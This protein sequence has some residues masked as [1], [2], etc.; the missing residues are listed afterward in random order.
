MQGTPS[1]LGRAIVTRNA[2][3]SGRPRGA[4]SERRLV[5]HVG[6]PKTGTTTIQRALTALEPQLRQRGV[7][8]PAAGRGGRRLAVHA[9]LRQALKTRAPDP[10]RGVL[11]ELL[12]ELRAS[13]AQQFV[14]S[15]EGLSRNFAPQAPKAIAK[16][17]ESAGLDVAIVGYVRPQC[18]YIESL[19]AQMVK[20]G[21]GWLPF[22]VF[23]G[24]SLLRRFRPRQCWLDY[25]RLFAPWR[26]TFGDRVIITPLEPSRFA[27]GLVA[28]FLGLLGVDEPAWRPREARANLRLGAKETE[29][30]RLTGAKLSGL[31]PTGHSQPIMKRLTELPRLLPSDAPFAG[32]SRA[33]SLDLMEFFAVANAAFARE[34]GIDGALFRDPVV[35]DLQRPN[36]AQWHDLEAGEQRAVR[37]YV[38]RTAGVDP[39][40]R[41]RRRTMRALGGGRLGSRRWFA[42]RLADPRIAWL[43]IVTLARRCARYL[44]GIAGRT[45]V[46]RTRS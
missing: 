38:Q 17:A 9:G 29:V 7:C 33:Q 5:V 20:N 43:G 21:W 40:P 41:G 39:A 13:D 36:V 11:G 35:D 25:S 15:D 34:Y 14:V 37:E 44:C 28:H 6:T 24:V 32:L 2:V 8:I 19:Y 4:P 46:A 23:V 30:R 16:L 22:D 1:T 45:T 42:T 12:D 10:T 31:R 18:Q 3:S 26:E 27:H